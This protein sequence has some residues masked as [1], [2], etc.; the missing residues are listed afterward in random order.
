MYYK[1][2][3]PTSEFEKLLH[4]AGGH[5]QYNIDQGE[6]H[7]SAFHPLARPPLVPSE[8]FVAKA[9]GRV[10]RLFSWSP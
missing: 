10:P 5:K 8:R 6:K 3:F 2:C 7:R 9:L 4:E 1:T